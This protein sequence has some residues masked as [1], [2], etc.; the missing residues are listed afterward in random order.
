MV[1][2]VLLS[3]QLS[4]AVNCMEQVYS[5]CAHMLYILGITDFSISSQRLLKKM[6]YYVLKL[7]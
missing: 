4:K 2:S 1:F 6:F 5:L 3:Y 7:G